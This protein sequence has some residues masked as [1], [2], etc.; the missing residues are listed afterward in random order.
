MSDIIRKG[1][2]VLTADMKAT[3]RG[4]AYDI[5]LSMPTVDRDGEVIEV[6]AFEPLPKGRLPIDVDHGMSTLTTVGSGVAEYVG[7]RLVLRDFRFASTHLGGEVKTLVDEGHVSKVSVAFMSAMRV[8]KNGI[9]HIVKAELL[10]AAIVAIPSNRE[11]DIV[12]AAKNFGRRIEVRHILH[13]AEQ[14]LI[15]LALEDAQSVLSAT[16]PPPEPP[17]TFR[18]GG[19]STRSQVDNYLRSV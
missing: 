1:V 15:E 6:R 4:D 5:T 17:L 7:D 11:A 10:N 13:E 3:R 16:A 18:S 19:G 8:T 12:L 2:R 9:P 14:V